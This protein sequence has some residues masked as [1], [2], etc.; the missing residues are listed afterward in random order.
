MSLLQPNPLLLPENCTSISPRIIKSPS[1]AKSK[2]GN[3]LGKEAE[4]CILKK[5]T[6]SEIKKPYGKG[7]GVEQLKNKP[8]IE[9]ARSANPY[10][11]GPQQAKD[12]EVVPS[13]GARV[14]A[15]AP[16]A[17]SSPPGLKPPSEQRGIWGMANRGGAHG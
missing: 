1:F 9:S 14:G 6:P 10:L 15:W 17:A 12:I 3:N 16:A 4:Y 11:N 8:R 13:V 5:Y 2:F 7:A